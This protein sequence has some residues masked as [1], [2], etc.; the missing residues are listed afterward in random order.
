M[1]AA[2][3]TW[4]KELKGKRVIHFIDNEAARLG[5]VKAYSPVL[6]SLSIIMDCLAWDYANHCESW[7]ARVPSKSNISDGPSRLD[8]SSVISDLGGVRVSPRLP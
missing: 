6:P 1:L 3:H 4:A 5:L 2:K 7:F 8:F